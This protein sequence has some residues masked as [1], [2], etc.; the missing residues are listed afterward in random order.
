MNLDRAFKITIGFKSLLLYVQKYSD[1]KK[2][3]RSSRL[4]FK[5]RIQLKGSSEI[6]SGQ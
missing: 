6:Q 5:Q 1:R 3:T 4:R 2:Q